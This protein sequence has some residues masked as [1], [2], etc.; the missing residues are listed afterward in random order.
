MK[1]IICLFGGEEKGESQEICQWWQPPSVVLL[2][3]H[4][5]LWSLGKLKVFYKYIVKTG[6]PR[7]SF[8]RREKCTFCG[9][10]LLTSAGSAKIGSVKGALRMF[11]RS[12]KYGN[13]SLCG[14][15]PWLSIK[16]SFPITKKHF[17]AHIRNIFSATTIESFVSVVSRDL[18]HYWTKSILFT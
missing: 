9:E 1:F 7:S 6:M 15:R 8:K 12:P 17:Y 4:L 18:L 5:H 16:L 14:L 13:N 3:E 10:T 2:V 11:L